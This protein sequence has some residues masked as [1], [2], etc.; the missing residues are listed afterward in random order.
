VNRVACSLIAL[1]LIACAKSKPPAAFSFDRDAGVLFRKNGHT[2]LEIADTTLANGTIQFL[3]AAMPQTVGTARVGTRAA[4]CDAI[5]SD[6]SRS[7]RYEATILTG[8]LDEGMPALAVAG[9]PRPLGVSDSILNADIDG[10]GRPDTFRFCTSSEGVH[11]TLWDGTPASG[12]REWHRY[13][14]VGYDLDPT[15]SEAET[16]PDER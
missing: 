3:G 8:S 4:A 2:C 11:L 13:V 10:D 15:C 16:K 9:L 12:R 5:F 1:G 14:Y 6:T 7:A